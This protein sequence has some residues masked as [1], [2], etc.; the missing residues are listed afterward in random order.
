MKILKHAVIKDQQ[1]RPHRL[2]DRGP[3]TDDGVRPYGLI[4][5]QERIGICVLIGPDGHHLNDKPLIGNGR[6]VALQFGHST[7]NAAHIVS[8]REEGFDADMSSQPR[9]RIRRKRA[10]S[11]TAPFGV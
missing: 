7:R 4:A 8:H 9:N 10:G 1:R 3:D 11:Q 5:I 2:A 6:K